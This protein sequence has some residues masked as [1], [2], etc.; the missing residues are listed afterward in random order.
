MLSV[1]RKEHGCGRLRNAKASIE[2]ARRR[3]CSVPCDAYYPMRCRPSRSTAVRLAGSEG[4]ARR[5]T[6][7]IATWWNFSVQANSVFLPISIV[8]GGC[9]R[10][11][12]R[13]RRRLLV[14]RSLRSLGTPSRM[15]RTRNGEASRCTMRKGSV[16]LRSTHAGA[17][18]IRFSTPGMISG[19]TG[20]IW[21]MTM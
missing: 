17:A 10:R 4:R 12:V 13:F 15:D 7:A 19:R 9:L 5:R 14:R 11:I 20:P 16:R 1:T 3:R 6:K 21:P 18:A 2:S 8:T